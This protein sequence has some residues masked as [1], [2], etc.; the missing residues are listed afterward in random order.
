MWDNISR[1]VIWALVQGLANIGDNSAGRISCTL[2]S[3]SKRVVGG[4]SLVTFFPVEKSSIRTPM[5]ATRKALE[6]DP[7]LNSV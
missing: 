7:M 2:V 3:Q 1:M 4:G 6:H 5:A